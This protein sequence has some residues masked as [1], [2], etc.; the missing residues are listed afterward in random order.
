MSSLTVE[1]TLPLSSELGGNS[2]GSWRRKEA[3]RVD[4]IEMGMIL[5]CEALHDLPPDEAKL[6][7]EANSYRVAITYLSVATA[8]VD[9]LVSRSKYLL[10]GCALAL[11]VN[12]RAFNP[13]TI[14]RRP[15]PKGSGRRAKAVVT[16]SVESP[17]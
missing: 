12:D 8:D 1:F 11:G 10:D 14:E 6:L 4:N 5:T 15:A 3:T 13:I 9:N 2:R 7:R 16:V 17:G